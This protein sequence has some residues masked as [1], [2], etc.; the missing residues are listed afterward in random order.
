MNALAVR[1]VSGRKVH[2]PGQVGRLSVT[3]TVHQTAEP[4]RHIAQGDAGSER[5]GKFP[6]RQLV[7]PNVED[8]GEAG[9]DQPPIENQ[10]APMYHEN[11]SPRR[12]RKTWSLH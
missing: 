1:L 2:G 5:V 10:P 9:P 4:A 12:R 8:G 7:L 6:Q 3:T 11:L